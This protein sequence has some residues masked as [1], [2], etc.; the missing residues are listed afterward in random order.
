MRLS[1]TI[2]T[3]LLAM[4]LLHLNATN[5]MFAAE[6][7]SLELTGVVDV[8]ADNI[9]EVNDN[10]AIVKSPL[11][12]SDVE[13][14]QLLVNGYDPEHFIYPVKIIVINN[15]QVDDLVGQS[16]FLLAAGQYEIIVEPDFSNI[17][18]PKIFMGAPWDE[19]HVSFNLE[20]D[21]QLV[22]AS[23]LTDRNELLWSVEIYSVD[24]KSVETFQ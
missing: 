1:N 4:T 22:I 3:S 5:T 13:H 14:G 10:A 7:N 21:Q 16:D 2:K 18:P 9:P 19:K 24:T 8:A 17:E 12:N 6:T 23:R 20:K 11:V 15:W